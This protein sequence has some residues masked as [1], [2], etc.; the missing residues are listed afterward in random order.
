M[1][2]LVALEKVPLVVAFLPKIVGGGGDLQ[3]L[4]CDS[5]SFYE[6]RLSGGKNE[7]WWGHSN[8]TYSNQTCLNSQQVMEMLKHLPCTY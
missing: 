4:L 7:M 8:F 2:L 1:K 3:I 5:L 6:S